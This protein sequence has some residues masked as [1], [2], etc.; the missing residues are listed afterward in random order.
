MR[1][2]ENLLGDYAPVGPAGNHHGTFL[3]S[4]LYGTSLLYCFDLRK[5]RQDE[6][7]LVGLLQIV[8]SMKY[9]GNY[10]GL[11]A[12]VVIVFLPT[13]ILSHP[14][15]REDYIWRYRRRLKRLIF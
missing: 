11:F 2:G 15:I 7:C 12:A 13:F 9:T 4:C 8:N 10:G 3:I 1:S 14:I 6:I 5:Y